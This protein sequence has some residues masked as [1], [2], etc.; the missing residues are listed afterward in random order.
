M[1]DQNEIESK[2]NK[3]MVPITVLRVDGG[4]TLVE[5]VQ[6][7]EAFRKVVPSNKLTPDNEIDDKSLSRGVSY[8]IAWAAEL[9]KLSLP[10]IITS[11]EVEKALH[12]A[13]IWDQDDVWTNSNA[14]V[15]ALQSLYAVD[16]GVI[17]QIAG[18]G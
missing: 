2:V 6:D 3:I 11:T 4:S 7:G 12:N 17:A 18:K 13:G 5:F 8:G 16:L 10:Q 1:P 9:D 15:G 14:V